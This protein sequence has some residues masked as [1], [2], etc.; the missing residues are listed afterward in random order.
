VPD[1]ELVIIGDGPL[2]REIELL[3]AAHELGGA[4]RLAGRLSDAERDGWLRR[5]HVFAM[6]S[7]LPPDGVGGEGFG[8]VYLEAS[9]HGLP[10]VAGNVGGAQD[11][12]VDGRTGV[13]VDPTD[14]VAVA[15]AIADLLLEPV[16]A[17]SL[18]RAGAGHARDFAWPRVAERVQELLLAVAN[19]RR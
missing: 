8:I 12:V 9:A 10:V 3:A 1:A 6:P 17:E 15:D 5:A 4:V 18:G 11:A 16:R 13:L 14:H 19:G 7:R 2:R